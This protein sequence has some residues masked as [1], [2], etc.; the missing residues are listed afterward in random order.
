MWLATTTSNTCR[1]EI[2]RCLSKHDISGGRKTECHLE[3][4]KRCRVF[5]RR[6]VAWIA[7]FCQSLN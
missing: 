7:T 6:Q 5:D 1:Q 2:G 3:L 4:F